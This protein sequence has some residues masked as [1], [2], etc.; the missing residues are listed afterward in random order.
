MAEAYI[1]PRLIAAANSYKRG[2]R[3]R[4]MKRTAE[5]ARTGEA[6]ADGVVQGTGSA[7]TQQELLSAE[8]AKSELRV[9]YAKLDMAA[10]VSNQTSEVAMNKLAADKKSKLYEAMG[11]LAA[12][13]ST[14][15]EAMGKVRVEA[16]MTAMKERLKIV[17]QING[18]PDTVST[19]EAMEFLESEGSGVG[20]TTSVAPGED[21]NRSSYA[22]QVANPKF[23]VGLRGKLKG[24]N[25]PE[26]L[27][28][29]NSIAQE[30]PDIPLMEMVYA[31]SDAEGQEAFIESL[32]ALRPDNPMGANEI[33]ALVAAVDT[34][35]PSIVT[36]MGEIGNLELEAKRMDGLIVADLA[37]AHKIQGS[38]GGRAGR[39]LL[40]AAGPEGAEMLA[41]M[42]IE[43]TDVNTDGIDAALVDTST[44]DQTLETMKASV[45]ATPQFAAMKQDQGFA[46]DEAAF[47]FLMKQ[48]PAQGKLNRWKKAKLEEER[49]GAEQAVATAPQASTAAQA[50]EAQ[51]GQVMP[52]DGSPMLMAKDMVGPK[53]SAEAKLR[54]NVAEGAG[55]ATIQASETP[56]VRGAP[57]RMALTPAQRAKDIAEMAASLKAPVNPARRTTGGRY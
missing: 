50:T 14:S 31:G 20:P 27:K 12:A 40:K 49:A 25:G 9:E 1:N 39:E 16:S 26:T 36:A 24:K 5:S 8:M 41:L 44:P 42:G 21:I 38:A 47:Q 29:L 18:E 15:G 7:P 4:A 22:D 43:P 17:H 34:T 45:I 23:W 52:L 6:V 46:T 13:N 3:G 33:K 48:A 19:N 51:S 32:Q 28:L 11:R 56:P 55:S 57:G 54:A 53:R 37:A 10:Q 35:T 30:M 2:A